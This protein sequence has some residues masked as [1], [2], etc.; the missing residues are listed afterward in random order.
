MSD[1]KNYLIIGG[2][3]G[4]G[5]ALANR[6][7]ERNNSVMIASRNAIATKGK[8]FNY[9]AMTDDLTLS[10]LP[11]QLHGLVYC[12]G[13]IN[14]K[15]FHRLSDQDFI[16]DFQLNVMGAIRTIRSV[17]PILKNSQPSSI[18]LFS[19][20]AVQQGM[21]FHSSVAAS[22]GAVE[23]LTRS[24]AAELAPRIRVNC[25]APSLTNTPLASK[26]LSSEE[27]KKAADDRHPLKRT[28]APEE[29][30][31]LA[32]FLLSEEASWI[33]GQVIAVD[34]GLSSIRA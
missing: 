27:K 2:N 12:P 19:T 18:L 20:V 15:P 5:L 25:I 13:T 30:A 17:L 10:D 34:G 1:T 8:S 29:L 24:L 7:A 21:A 6:L 22:K 4:I 32:A 16:D 23:G 3:S 14:L 9:N 33:T 31:A 28:G 26:L 11:E